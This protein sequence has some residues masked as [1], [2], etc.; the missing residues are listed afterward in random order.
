MNVGVVAIDIAIFIGPNG[1]VEGVAALGG[2]GVASG[3]VE[4][5]EGL[6]DEPSTGEDI[7]LADFHLDGVDGRGRLVGEDEGNDKG[8]LLAE[9]DGIDAKARGVVGIEGDHAGGLLTG[10]AIFGRNGG[11]FHL[12]A[13]AP[14]LVVIA[15]PDPIGV[16]D[17]GIGHGQLA[18]ALDLA[19]HRRLRQRTIRADE[20]HMADETRREDEA[21]EA[22]VRA[23]T[24]G[25]HQSPIARR[26]ILP[27]RARERL[28]DLAGIAGRARGRI[29]LKEAELLVAAE[30]AAIDGIANR[31][32]DRD[33]VPLGVAIG[34][35]CRA[36]ISSIGAAGGLVG[37]GPLGALGNIR[38]NAG[39]SANIDHLP[40]QLNRAGGAGGIALARD[41][42]RFVIQEPAI[43]RHSGRRRCRNHRAASDI[44]CAPKAT[45]RRAA[46]AVEDVGRAIGR[47]DGGK[48]GHC[49]EG[50]GIGARGLIVGA[51]RSRAGL[52]AG[53]GVALDGPAI[54]GGLRHTRFGIEDAIAQVGHHHFGVGGRAGGAINK[55]DF[56]Q[57]GGL[58][59]SAVKVEVGRGA[60]V[61][62]IPIGHGLI[63]RRIGEEGGA[64]VNRRLREEEGDGLVA[65]IGLRHIGV[66]APDAEG[67]G[68][69]LLAPGGRVGR[70]I[71]QGRGIGVAHDAD[72]RSGERAAGGEIL[73]FHIAG[74]A[75]L[76][77][78]P[79]EGGNGIGVFHTLKGGGGDAASAIAQVLETGPGGIEAFPGIIPGS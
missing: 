69:L 62:H 31:G 5:V 57:P 46:G 1:I 23:R 6:G 29:G 52:G 48:V 72:G 58:R 73:E 18:Q 7:A 70:V 24:V 74:L 65:A 2:V 10:G 77:E 39:L 41:D 79:L 49:A 61:A 55:I 9:G 68:G 8:V 27:R 3:R 67:N 75:I 19:I 45:L 21:L 76:G 78:G 22:V 53:F 37:E 47:S 38:G 50:V 15:H 12:G 56:A 66:N 42:V 35:E 13:V 26:V 32:A 60:G 36:V 71:A 16:A 43:V 20:H 63:P 51:N 30:H 14:G 54:G 28:G 17:V 44:G 11:V 25:E 4:R 64:L 33:A 40:H 34:R 59:R